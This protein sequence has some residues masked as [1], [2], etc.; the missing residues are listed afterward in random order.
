MARLPALATLRQ[1]WRALSTLQIGLLISVAVHAGLLTLRFAA[2]ESFNRIFED[3]PLEVV[4]V[5]AASTEAPAKAQVIAQR[6]L[7]GGGDSADPR[8]RATSPLPPSATLAEGEAAQ[9]MRRQLE[10]LQEQQL[11]LLAQ[12]RAELAKLSAPDPLRDQGD[13]RERAVAEQRKQL[14]QL[15]AQI[16]K[17]INAENARPKRRYVSP[18]AREG[19][20]A[21]YYDALR[22]RIED[23]GTQNFPEAGGRKLYGELT[24]VVAID[25]AGRVVEVEI[26]ESSGNA[27]LDR[28]AI[29][30]VR[31]AAPFGNFSPAMRQQFDQLVFAS[32][33]RFTRDEA[34]RATVQDAP[35]R[36]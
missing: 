36:P 32:R 26:V 12:V 20:H 28:R 33:F 16:E 1:R 21:L 27:A 25:A 6:Q 10:A 5:N 35:R 3:T 30:I 18:A 23:T 8:E 14:L 11:Q 29:G 24:M 7:A 15:L 4:L 22:R 17:R 13:P 19:V 34:L 2:P 9:D 31:K